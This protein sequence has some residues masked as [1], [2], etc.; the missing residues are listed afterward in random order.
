LPTKSG[1][2]GLFFVA[3][4]HCT[5][6]RMVSTA[7]KTVNLVRPVVVCYSAMGSSYYRT[8]WTA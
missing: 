7:L 8:Q 2:Y 1:N 6:C 4:I 3:D 5:E